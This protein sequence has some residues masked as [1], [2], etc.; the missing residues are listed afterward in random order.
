MHPLD[1]AMQLELEGKEFYLKQAAQLEDAHLSAVF[2]ELAQDE[3]K[4]YQLLKQIKESGLYDYVESEILE[5]VPSIFAEPAV[6][7]APEKYTSYV[8]IYRQA[9]EFEQRAVDL[10]SELARKAASQ[11]EREVFFL[12]EREEEVHRTIIQKILQ[13][14]QSPEQWYPY[15]N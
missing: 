15:L 10:Y 11:R 1:F 14:L 13:L 12:L 2:E 8:E 7:A 3:E 5:R 6:R 4:H 9:L